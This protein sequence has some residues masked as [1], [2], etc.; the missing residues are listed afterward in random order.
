MISIEK[1]KEDFGN[2]QNSL[3]KLFKKQCINTLSDNIVYI[4]ENITEDSFDY[5]KSETEKKEELSN[6]RKSSLS[7]LTSIIYNQQDKIS[8]I[9]LTILYSDIDETIIKCTLVKLNK[10]E[11]D[12]NY[13]CALTLPS[14]NYNGER[15]DIN[16]V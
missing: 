13:H 15:Y 2:I 10:T 8:W 1:I 14:L 11:K 6:S 5:E 12:I 3:F 7:E 9:D 4:I 16:K